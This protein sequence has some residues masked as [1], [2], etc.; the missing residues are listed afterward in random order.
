MP[1]Y[2]YKCG[3]CGTITEEGRPA[4]Y[5]DVSAIC[6]ACFSEAERIYSAGTFRIEHEVP[7]VSRNSAGETIRRIT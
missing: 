1:L 6:P 7:E 5:R 3:A 4:A 2:E